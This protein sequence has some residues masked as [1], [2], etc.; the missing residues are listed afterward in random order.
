M[1]KGKAETPE[2]GRA[3]ILAAEVLPLEQAKM[4]E[5]RFVTIRVPVETWDRAKGERLRDIL[6]AHRGDCPV[7]LELVRPG[8]FAAAVAPSGYYRVRPDST[9]RDEVEALLGQGR[10]G[11]GRERAAAA[12]DAAGPR[13]PMPEADFEAP[14][15]AL[16]KRVPSCGPFPGDPAKE[17]EARKL[18]EELELKRREVFAEPHALAEDPGGAQPEPPLHPRLRRRPSSPSGPRST[19]TGGTATTPPSS[20]ASRSTRTGRWRCWATRRAATPSR[21]STAT[22]ACPS[23]RATGRPC[24]SCRWRPSSAG[25]SSPSWTR[26]G[27]IPGSTPRSAGRPRPSPTTCARWPRLRTPIVVTV[28]GEGGSGGAL[29]IAVGDR[30]NMLEHSVYSVISPEGCAS[31]LWRDAAR[32]EDAAQAMKITAPDLAR[33]R[34]RG[35]DHPRAAGGRPR[36]TPSRSSRRLDAVLSRQLRELRRALRRGP[37]GGPL[38]ASSGRWAGWAGSSSSRRADRGAPRRLPALRPRPVD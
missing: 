1:V 31:I 17:R 3:R 21:R 33:P 16:Q 9:L 23:P 7:T 4:A 36:R 22:S 20:A 19:A 14:L 5:A 38:P 12:E 6:G 28:T 25:P 35:R 26:R 27:P 18:E 11:A 2:D 15:L 34:H 30:V 13:G 10:P 24:A 29:A 32:A 37:R 8:A